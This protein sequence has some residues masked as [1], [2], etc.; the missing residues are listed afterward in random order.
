MTE[1]L[2]LGCLTAVAWGV[3]SMVSAPA[4]RI[5]GVAESALWLS[6]AATL[7][8]AV[9]AISF[10]G[11]PRVATSDLPYL[12]MA[13]LSLLG[14][15]YLWALLVNRSEV[16][17]AT[18]IVA[19][20]GAIAASMAVL[21]GD[22]LPAEAHVGLAAMVIGLLVLSR[23]QSATASAGLRRHGVERRFSH[24]ATVAVAVLTAT[25]FGGMFFFS[26]RVDETPVLWTA[27]MVRGSVTIVA[28]AL[29]ASRRPSWPRAA[30]LR[31]AVAAGLLDVSGFGLYIAGA[32]HDL[33]VA[34]VAASQYAAVAVFASM[35][36][37]RERLTRAQWTGTAVLV[38]G[39]AIVAAWGH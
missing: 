26:G 16:S 1:A 23:R 14:A 12:G 6:V 4:S 20:D 22:A 8:G 9:L 13:A 35:L 11:P 39:A 30:G 7:A 18:P 3:G 28:L 25:C 17:L 32:R 29:T 2:F 34:A 5:L 31:F 38:A 37:L 19:C 36:Y 21:A 24:R 33:A 15:T 27:T 10:S